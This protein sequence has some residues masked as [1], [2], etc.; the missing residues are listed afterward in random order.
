MTREKHVARRGRGE[1]GFALVLA[2]LALMLLTF[3]GLT[4]AA[5]TSTELQ[6]ATNYRW[7]Q[8]ALYNAEAG[9]EAA[10]LI[11]SNAGNPTTQWAALLP[12]A[13]TVPWPPS[14]S[15]A[16]L[17]PGVPGSRDY[18]G[19]CP[20][21]RFG[22][23]GYGKVLDTGGTRFENVA[24]FMGQPLNGGFTLWIR[25][26]LKVDNSGQFSDNT[27]NEIVIVTSEGVAP[28]SPV[29]AAAAAAA[30]TQANQ[31]VRVLEM[32][33]RFVVNKQGEAC[34]T[35]H[36]GQIGLGSSGANFDPCSPIGPGS[37][38]GMLGSAPGAL[39][40]SGG[41]AIE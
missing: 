2:I 17:D 14:G 38:A 40:G 4:L 39:T 24:Q 18:Y 11:L 20:G 41:A 33:Y 13:R 32:S 8:Q 21:D 10:K 5:T 15:S 27:S 31:A 1:S 9:L 35:G 16:P 34:S 22:G 12:T 30:F 23:I 26:G 36:S 7:S 37:L 19:A 6:I 28:Y 3:L 25:R 29:A